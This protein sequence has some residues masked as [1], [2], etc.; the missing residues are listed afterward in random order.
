MQGIYIIL[1][2]IVVALVLNQVIGLNVLQAKDQ[3]NLELEKAANDILEIMTT[4]GN[5]LGYQ[6]TGTIESREVKLNNHHVID[7]NKLKEFASTYS[8]TEPPCARDYR[9]RFNFQVE[10]SPLSRDHT[11]EQTWSIGVKTHSLGDAG[12]A[13]I[14]ISSPISVRIDDITTQPALATLTLY[15][16]ELEEL[17]GLIDQVCFTNSAV[18]SELT[19]SYTTY[20]SQS[21]LCMSYQSGEFCL[22]LSCKKNVD[23]SKVNPGNY[24]ITIKPFE[25]RI[26]V[27]I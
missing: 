17:T 22:K 23:F 6:E 4:S 5:C 2:L 21:G 20:K 8:D 7:V 15:D 14:S 19:L 27:E 3:R 16:G 13:A 24:K 26:K 25:D 1:T 9:F 11:N 18:N 10:L 12:R